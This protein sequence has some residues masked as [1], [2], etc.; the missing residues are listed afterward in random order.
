M[1][2]YCLKF[3]N[4]SQNFD[5]RLLYKNI[6]F[7]LNFSDTVLLTGKNGSGKSTLLKLANGLLKPSKGR[8]FSNVPKHEQGYLGHSTFLYPQLTAYQNLEFWTKALAKNGYGA[9]ELR[10]KIIDTLKLV[11]LHKFIDDTVN[12]FSRGMAQRLNIAR[13]IMQ[14]PK[15]LMLDEPCT[16]LDHESKS[17]FYSCIENFKQKNTC[18]LWVS[19]DFE[20]DCKYADKNFHIADKEIIYREISVQ[21][22]VIC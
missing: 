12:I 8:I 6:N 5:L 17:I 20:S 4:V 21:K 10:E 9:K 19:H 14:K 22:E 16:G 15:L 18:I 7:E 2:N 3:E 13:I 11:N 1:E